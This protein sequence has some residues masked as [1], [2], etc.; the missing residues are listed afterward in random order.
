MSR[1]HALI[2]NPVFSCPSKGNWR[3]KRCFSQP[4]Q[5]H[6]HIHPARVPTSHSWGTPAP[7]PRGA[8]PGWLCSL[9]QPEGRT[10]PS[11]APS[12][13]TSALLFGPRLS[14]ASC[15]KMPFQ[16]PPARAMPLGR[17]LWL[18]TTAAPLCTSTPPSVPGKLSP[19][20]L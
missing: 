10:L 5:S 14:I 19:Q 8:Q 18:R 13:L 16:A 9:H 17:V 20:T 1:K 3:R 11:Q 2:R 6:W 4:S 15:K 7:A 12:F